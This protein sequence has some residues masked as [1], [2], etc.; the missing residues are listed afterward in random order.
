MTDQFKIA[1]PSFEESWESGRRVNPRIQVLE[2]KSREH[3]DGEPVAWVLIERQESY[4]YD[5]EDGSVIE[6]SIRFFYERI[7]LQYA[8]RSKDKGDFGGCYSKHSNSVS[9]TSP[10]TGTTGFVI[11]D[12]QGL[13][14]HRIGTYL[15]NEIVS[16]AQRWPTAIVNSV[17]LLVGQSGGDNKN[18]RNNFYENFGLTFDYSDPEHKEGRSLPVLVSKLKQRE[19]WKQNIAEIRMLDFLG[20]VLRDEQRATSELLFRDR[21][22][23]DLNKERKEAVAKPIRWALRTTWLWQ[24]ERVVGSIFAA[25]LLTVAWFKYVA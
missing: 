15:M 2:V 13:E 10:S 5:P 20:K 7:H 12:L 4:R 18:R 8:H 9:L 25:A 16:W 6:A 19:T 1:Q 21:A 3:P 24:R 17:S 11:L 14:G 22:I 23:Q